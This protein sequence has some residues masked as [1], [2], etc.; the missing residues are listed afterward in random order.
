[1]EAETLMARPVWPRSQRQHEA[2]AAEIL[3]RHV[4]STGI[5]VSFP[6]PIEMIVTKTFDLEIEWR[7]IE[8]P[9]GSTILGALAPNDHRIFLNERHLEMFESWV[10]PERFTLAHELAHWVYDADSPDQLLLPLDSSAPLFCY[11]RESST[12]LSDDVAIREVNANKLAASLLL[13]EF[14][15]RQAA[16][17]GLLADTRRFAA[18]WGVSRTTLLIRLE[19]LGLIKR[20][21]PSPDDDAVA[22]ALLEDM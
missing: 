22:L 12:A 6:V 8:E 2:K 14:L 15:V 11:H 10:G 17:P 5:A 13:P 4:R 20:S 16:L 7:T 3:G 1:L 9:E 18:E 19:T 21:V